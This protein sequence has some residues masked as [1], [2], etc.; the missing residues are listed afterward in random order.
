MPAL[1]LLLGNAFTGVVAF[2]ATYLTKKAAVV[3]ALS[4]FL[5]GGWIIL[6]T[7]LFALWTALAFVLPLELVEPLRVAGYLLPSNTTACVATLVSARLGRWLWDRQR[8]WAQ[9]VASA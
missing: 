2:L 4:T 1:A 9:V 7:S 6:Q 8:E 5:I 3:I